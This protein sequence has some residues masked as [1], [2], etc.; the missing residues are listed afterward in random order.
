MFCAFTFLLSAQSRLGFGFS[1]GLGIGILKDRP[2]NEW[3]DTCYRVSRAGRERY[4]S[5]TYLLLA[6]VR[7]QL[8]PWWSV[9]I[10]SGVGLTNRERTGYL[11]TVYKDIRQTPLRLQLDVGL[12]RHPVLDLRLTGEVGLLFKKVV[13]APGL[14]EET[15]RWGGAAELGVLPH[16]FL[17]GLV[18]KLGCEFQQDEVLFDINR[19]FQLGRD[20]CPVYTYRVN[21]FF[22]V[23]KLEFR[24]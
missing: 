20:A 12:L 3:V 7:Y 14:I 5:P 17:E 6:S 22:A 19:I 11:T 4:E 15:G 8:S 10:V 13:I 24:F 2:V 18:F 1:A 23:A 16:G 21:R 9:G